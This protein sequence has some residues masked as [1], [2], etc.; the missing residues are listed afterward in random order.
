ME[1]IS[2]QLREARLHIPH[3]RVQ[4]KVWRSLVRSSKILN[5]TVFL[6][7]V[8][9]PFSKHVEAHQCH[10]NVVFKWVFDYFLNTL[11][12]F[13]LFFF[14]QRFL[15]LSWHW[16]LLGKMFSKENL[17]SFIVILTSL[18]GCLCGTE[19]VWSCRR[20]MPWTC[21]KMTPS[22]TSQLLL[23]NIKEIIRAIWHWSQEDFAQEIATLLQLKF[24]VSHCE[25]KKYLNFGDL[26]NHF[27]AKQPFF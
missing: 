22:W 5:C 10:L 24:M 18:T 16:W 25:Y 4:E 21:I 2:A 17:C 14:S 3:T 26:Q 11:A 19:T 1:S 12:S 8:L 15:N 6:L 13:F 20:M 27:S 7:H 23:K 9:V